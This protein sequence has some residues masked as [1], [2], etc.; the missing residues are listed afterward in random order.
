MNKQ[1]NFWKL[2]GLLDGHMNGWMDGGW[3]GKTV[4][5]KC[6]WLGKWVDVR[7]MWTKLRYESSN[8]NAA[9]PGWVGLPLP[10][11]IFIWSHVHQ[12]YIIRLSPSKM[13]LPMFPAQHWR[14]CTVGKFLKVRNVNLS[15]FP[16]KVME[17]YEVHIWY[18]HSRLL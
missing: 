14:S 6:W 4:G 1:F 10:S 13:F 9:Y 16:T 2:N 15:L 18:D 17:I 3:D 5:W 8:G 7:N 11:S 12:F